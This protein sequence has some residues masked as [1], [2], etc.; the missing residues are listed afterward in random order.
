M[1][2]LELVVGAAPWQPRWHSSDIRAADRRR[3]A[4]QNFA[5]L[6]RGKHAQRQQGWEPN[7]FVD[8][9]ALRV[10]SVYC[11]A[12]VTEKQWVHHLR[13]GDVTERFGTQLLSDTSRLTD[14]LVTATV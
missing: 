9:V 7:D 12:M 11:D 3:H 2:G 5:V 8:V 14:V 13:L 10:P 1:A 4:E 6:R